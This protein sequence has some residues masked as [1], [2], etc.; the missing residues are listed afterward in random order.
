MVNALRP[1]F[2]GLGKLESALMSRRLAANPLDRPIYI[3][4]VPRCGTTVTLDLLSAHPSVAT[5]RYADMLLPY[6]PYVWNALAEQLL[7]VIP[8][9]PQER[10]HQDGLIVTKASPEGAEE[11]LWLAFFDQLHSPEVSCVLGANDAQP[12]FDRFYTATIQKLLLARGRSRFLSKAN[13]NV[14]RL[15]YLHRLFPEARF[16]LFIRHPVH[17]VASLMKTDRLFN[18]LAHDDARVGR[19][20]ALT[21]HFEF[22]PAKRWARVADNIG[23]IRGAYE[24]GQE[25]RSWAMHWSTVY[26]LVKSQLDANPSL[27]ARTLVVRYEDLCHAPGETIDRI[28][29]HCE[30]DPAP[31]AAERERSLQ[32]LAEPTY[33]KPRFDAAELNE[34]ETLTA[35]T[36]RSYGY[37][38]S[39]A[40]ALGENRLVG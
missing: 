24:R 4:G 10:I 19:M 27:A 8:D 16:L 12:A 20:T 3:C 38:Q 34:L 29:G 1:L 23:E 21:G 31:F 2:V 11:L 32:R 39:A 5:Q 40:E 30:L 22:G 7:K 26:D 25:A 28:L 6:A 37:D 18:K 33:Y 35:T 17:H 14:T 15:L 13:E 36:R 9:E